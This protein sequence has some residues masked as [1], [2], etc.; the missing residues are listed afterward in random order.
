MRESRAPEEHPLT[1]VHMA[2]SQ[3]AITAYETFKAEFEQRAAELGVTAVDQLSDAEC[4]TVADAIIV[5]NWGTL[6]GQKL[7][8]DGFTVNP[9]VV[10]PELAEKA[11]KAGLTHRQ[12]V[13]F[14]HGAYDAPDRMKAFE[15]ELARYKKNTE[16]PADPNRRF[17]NPF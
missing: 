11:A 14:A 16:Q 1:G 6:Y 10:T 15:E 3:K 12:I 7:A 5:N 4:D 9:A 2:R 17:G 8:A 13:E